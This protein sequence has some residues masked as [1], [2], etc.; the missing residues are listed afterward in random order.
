MDWM[1]VLNPLMGY[2][3]KQGNYHIY[4]LLQHSATLHFSY[5]VYD[6][7]I[8]IYHVYCMQCQTLYIWQIFLCNTVWY[9]CSARKYLVAHNSA[10]WLT[11]CNGIC[12]AKCDCCRMCNVRFI[13]KSFCVRLYTSLFIKRKFDGITK[14]Q[15]LDKL[16]EGGTY[17]IC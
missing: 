17:N 12:S 1:E 11:K 7:N 10:V 14:L 3:L 15:Q 16:C 13:E 5:T 4:H 9:L 2:S 6:D 8:S